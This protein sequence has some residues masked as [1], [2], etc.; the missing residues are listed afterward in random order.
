[1]GCE[2]CESGE[3]P[4]WVFHPGQ[5]M[6]EQCGERIAVLFLLADARKYCDECYRWRWAER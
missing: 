3:H 5:P 4:Q 6:C 1:M 2:S